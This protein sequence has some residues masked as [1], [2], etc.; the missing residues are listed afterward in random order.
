MLN[1]LLPDL[2]SKSKYYL[3]LVASS[4]LHNNQLLSTCPFCSVSSSIEF[5]QF[6]RSMH[7]DM[8]F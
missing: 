5:H 7:A 4:S 1:Y 6:F 2:V 3:R 8:F